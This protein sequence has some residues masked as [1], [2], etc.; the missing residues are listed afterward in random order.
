MKKIELTLPTS[1]GEIINSKGHLDIVK[2]QYSEIRLSFGKSVWKSAL[3]TEAPDWKYK[4]GLWNKYLDDIGKLFFS[5]YPY[6]VDSGV[7]QFCIIDQL[8][9]KIGIPPIKVD[10]SRLLCKGTSLNLGEEYIVITTK[11]ETC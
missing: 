9:A 10:L 7:H 2:N 5:E 4:E 8:V 11:V 1:L 3:H 6:V